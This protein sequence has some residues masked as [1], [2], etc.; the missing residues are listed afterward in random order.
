ML[1]ESTK[2]R[3]KILQEVKEGK[4]SSGY[5]AIRK[6]GNRPGDSGHSAVVISSFAEQ[7]LTAQQSA[8]RLADHFSAISKTVDP[9]AMD[10]FPP[11]LRQ[12]L[13][14]GRT[15]LHKPVLD[16]YQVYSKMCKVTKPKSTVLGDVPVD[17]MKQFTFEYAKPVAMLFNKII[18][19]SYWPSHWKV[20][21]TIVLSKC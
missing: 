15:D 21:Q 9:L 4:R 8:N 11:A 12:T 2:Y 3:N 7:G 10:K 14:E 1:A 20:E 13:E 16:Q 18:Q 17:I 5:N 6:L 19:S